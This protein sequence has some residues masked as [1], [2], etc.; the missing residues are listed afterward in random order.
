ML[1]KLRAGLEPEPLRMYRNPAVVELKYEEIWKD[2]FTEP[3][4]AEVR[5]V[6]GDE[7]RFA[8]APLFTINEVNR[9]V[10]AELFGERN[11][12]IFVS[13]R[14]TNFGQTR[15]LADAGSLMKIVWHQVET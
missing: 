14:P 5:L 4:E 7:S 2:P 1:E 12:R 3:S 10:K 8:F 9:T 11:G 6:I 13:F 15:F